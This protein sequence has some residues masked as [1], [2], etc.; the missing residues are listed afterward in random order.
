MIPTEGQDRKSK[1]GIAIIRKHHMVYLAMEERTGKTL[2]A[3]LICEEINVQ[4]V[5]V[6]T[7]KKALDGWAKTLAA[8]KHK[9]NY[10]VVNYQQLSKVQPGFYDIIIFDE[11]HN[12]ISSFPKPSVLWKICKQYA[13]GLPI[14]YMSATPHAQGLQLLYHQLALSDWSPFK[15]WTTGY[16]WFRAF[17][18]P[19]P[20]YL[21]GRSFESY[22]NFQDAEIRLYCANLM[23]T[24]TRKEMGFEQEPTDHLHY[25]DLGQTT[26]DVY[27][28]LQ[29]H[30]V[31]ELN[32]MDLVCDTSMK[33]RTSLHMLEGGVAKIGKQYVVL[34]NREKIDYILEHW[35]DNEDVA[36]MYQYIAEG[37]KLREEFKFAEVLQAT[38]NA[39]GVDLSHRQHLIIYSQDFSTARH[40]QRRARQANMKRKTAINVHYLLSSVSKGKPISAQVYETVSTNKTNFVDSVF[41]AEDI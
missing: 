6:V 32:G 38:S 18:I 28:L 15:K 7:K 26:K 31:I 12:Y 35:G 10:D 27:N 39:E 19:T 13:K 8:F 5:L 11:A 17:G 36:I 21:A 14:I 9:K 37:T 23:I 16:N 1:E 22:K 4:D 20:V 40:S 25:V 33:L 29:K 3:I 41:T 34:G 2:T 30:R 24:A